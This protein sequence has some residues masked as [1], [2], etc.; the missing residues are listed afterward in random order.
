MKIIRSYICQQVC[1]RKSYKVAAALQGK[2]VSALQQ[3]FTGVLHLP[4]L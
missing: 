2:L 1:K 4:Q 3:P